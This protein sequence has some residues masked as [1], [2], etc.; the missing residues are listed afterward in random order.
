[1]ISQRSL[2][3]RTT[4]LVRSGGQLTGPGL[5]EEAPAFD[6]LVLGYLD[7]DAAACPAG[8]PA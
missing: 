8:T 7:G 2:G 5:R 6:E 3:G 4:A 1:V